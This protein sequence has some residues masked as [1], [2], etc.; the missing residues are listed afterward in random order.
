[1][2]RAP[3]CIRQSH[4]IPA[5]CVDGLLGGSA[6]FRLTHRS[7]AGRRFL[8]FSSCFAARS[9]CGGVDLKRDKDHIALSDEHNARG[10]ELADHGMLDEAMREFCKAIELDPDSAHAHDNLATVLTEKKLF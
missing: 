10:I 6:S 7:A 1:S 5:G 3:A 2:E 4:M 8:E 9:G